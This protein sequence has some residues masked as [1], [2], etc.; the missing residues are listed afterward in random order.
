MQGERVSEPGEFNKQ[1]EYQIYSSKTARQKGSPL[2]KQVSEPGNSQFF[3]LA[4]RPPSLSAE[5][6]SHLFIQFSTSWSVAVEV[7]RFLLTAALITVFREVSLNAAFPLIPLQFICRAMSFDRRK[8]RI[9]HTL[10]FTVVP[11]LKANVF[12]CKNK[13]MH[14]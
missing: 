12:I 7:K 3:C 11:P 4:R 2:N 8:L 5:S 13:Y 6:C 9:R 14:K 10:S 1:V